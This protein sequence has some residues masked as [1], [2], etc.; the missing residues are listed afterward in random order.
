MIEC[1]ITDR[2]SLP[3][4]QSLLD[5]ISRNLIAGPDWIQIR[6]KEVTARELC[7][8]VR[9]VCDLANPRGVK[10]LVNSRVDVALATSAQGAHLPSHSPPPHLWRIVLP[11]G[12]LIGV[13]CHSAEDVRE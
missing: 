11:P 6:D 4:G 10:I 12:F 8:L 3:A 2:Q 13:S 7:A 9:A 5:T 1:Y